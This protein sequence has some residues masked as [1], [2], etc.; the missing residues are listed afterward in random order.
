M[1]VGNHSGGIA[2]DAAMVIAACLLE[3]HPPRL[4]QTMTD[5]F[6]ARMPWLGMWSFR[7]GQL[8]GL[9]HHAERLLADERLLARVSAGGARNRK[10]FH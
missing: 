9:P 5:K 8:T 10:A 3:M 4:A 6:F 1:L 7:M 2:I